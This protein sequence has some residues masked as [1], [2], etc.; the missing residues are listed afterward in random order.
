VVY[1]EPQKGTELNVYLPVIE[2]EVKE[3]EA[4][5]HRFPREPSAFC[6]LMTNSPYGI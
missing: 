1:S 6:L 4:L 2:R 3:E 5:R